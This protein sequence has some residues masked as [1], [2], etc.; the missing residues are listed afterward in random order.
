MRGSPADT[1]TVMR[2][3]GS[4]GSRRKKTEG[5]TTL[6][7]FLGIEIDTELLQMCLPQAKLKELISHLRQWMQEGATPTPRR[8]GTKQDLLSLIGL[9]NHAATVVKPGWTFLR[10][11]IDAS[12]TVKSLEHHVHLSAH[13]RVDLAWWYT[14]VQAWNGVSLLPAAEPSQAIYSDGVVGPGGTTNGSRSLGQKT[15]H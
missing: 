12:S 9:L 6:L 4:A 8:S 13:A 1:P 2:G 15:G 3:I 11:L 5:P 10:S 14:F 7:E